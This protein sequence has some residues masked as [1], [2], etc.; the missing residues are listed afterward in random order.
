MKV[1]GYDFRKPGRLVSDVELQESWPGVSP[2]SIRL[3]PREPD[4]QYTRLM[5][6]ETLVAVCSFAIKGSF[7]EQV[8]RWIVNQKALLAF[9]AQALD[10]RQ[11]R[12]SE[13]ETRQRMEYLVKELPVQM[14]VTLGTADLP[15]SLL[16]GLRAGDLVILNQRVS[17]PLP[18]CV[19]GEKKFRVW[20]GRVGQQ[21]AIQIHSSCEF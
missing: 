9:L 1:E 7:G 18:A 11:S 3:G 2:P 6:P 14:V 10:S 19:A 17:E 21:Q 5:P 16:S 8:W 4:P 15:L 12:S 13:T 20:P